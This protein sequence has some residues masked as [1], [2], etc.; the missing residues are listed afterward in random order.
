[1]TDDPIVNSCL[2][3]YVSGMTM[4]ETT[5]TLRRTTQRRSFSALIDH[6]IWFHRPADLSD[7]VLS[8]QV[9]PSGIH[10][11]GLATATMNNRAGQLVCTA[12][13]ELYFGR[14]RGR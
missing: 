8:D 2:L 12:T 13:Q 6:A 9:S 1:V 14:D 5:M 11:R 7:W 3:T 10:G 4:L